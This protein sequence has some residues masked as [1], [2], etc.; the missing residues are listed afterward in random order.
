MKALLLLFVLVTT[1]VYAQEELTISMG[2]AQANIVLKKS[3]TVA[4]LKSQGILSADG[5]EIDVD[6]LKSA[7]PDSYEIDAS[8]ASGKFRVLNVSSPAAP[9]AAKKTCSL[10]ITGFTEDADGFHLKYNFSGG[11]SSDY[12][13]SFEVTDDDGF[14]TAHLL[15]QE[16]LNQITKTPKDIVNQKEGTIILQEAAR[17]KLLKKSLEKFISYNETVMIPSKNNNSVE[18]EK[19]KTQNKQVSEHVSDLSDGKLSIKEFRKI[20]A[21]IETNIE[22]ENMEPLRLYKVEGPS[23]LGAGTWNYGVDQAFSRCQPTNNPLGF[24]FNSMDLLSGEPKVPRVNKSMS[25]GSYKTS[26]D[27]LDGKDNKSGQSSSKAIGQ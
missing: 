27:F 22:D 11:D 15:M 2:R 26:F 6:K 18:I 9:E 10:P 14:I 4:T 17:I 3:L 24:P 25:C 8:N 5:A 21:F 7:Y 20:A 23:C 13:G 16:T 19:I 1:S 12:K